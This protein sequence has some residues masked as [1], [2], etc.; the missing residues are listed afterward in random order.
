MKSLKPF[1]SILIAVLFITAYEEVRADGL[2]H[3]ETRAYVG[4]RWLFGDARTHT[5]N[6]V[7]GGDLALALRLEN[8]K[9]D[10][11]RLS[12]LE[13]K[14]DYVGQYGIGYSLKKQSNLFFVGLVGPYSKVSAEI[15]SGKNP[16]AGLELN[17]QDCAGTRRI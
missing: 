15:D 6:V 14:C 5:N 4:L 2:N 17:T 3:D 1:T 16:A 9:P 13:G 11:I 12:F 8:F 10:E 7:T